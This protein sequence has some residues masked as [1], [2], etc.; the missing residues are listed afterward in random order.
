VSAVNL[1]HLPDALPA[2]CHKPSMHATLSGMNADAAAAVT[3]GAK[4]I[5]IYNSA[6]NPQ[7]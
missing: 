1:P 6:L 5:R 4:T 7:Q 2:W 3:V